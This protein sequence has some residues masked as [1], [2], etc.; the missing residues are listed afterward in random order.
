M[1]KHVVMWKLKETANPAEK[2]QIVDRLKTMVEDLPRQVDLIKGL[3][4]GI[5]IARVEPAFDIV[6]ILSF[7]H[8]DG[9]L[10]TGDSTTSRPAVWSCITTGSNEEPVPR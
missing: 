1:I 4:V 2:Q 9:L 10:R 3:E 8:W 7:D 5:N 6:A